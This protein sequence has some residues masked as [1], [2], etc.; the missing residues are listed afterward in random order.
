LLQKTIAMFQF[1]DIESNKSTGEDLTE[2]P[3][4]MCGCT[5]VFPIHKTSFSQITHTDK[6]IPKMHIHYLVT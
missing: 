2:T 4:P 5:K 3:T 1:M 6:S